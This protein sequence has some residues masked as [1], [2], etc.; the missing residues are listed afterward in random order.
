[1]QEDAGADF[2]LEYPF[3]DDLDMNGWIGDEAL[4]EVHLPHK[5]WPVPNPDESNGSPFSL[6]QRDYLRVAGPGVFVGCAYRGQQPEAIS[7]EDCVYFILA[8]SLNKEDIMIPKDPGTH[9][10]QNKDPGVLQ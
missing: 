2:T 9:S 10:G 6:G 3:P 7:E 4:S 1:M 5:S 8:R